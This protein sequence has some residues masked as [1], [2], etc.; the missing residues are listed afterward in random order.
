MT[1]REDVTILVVDD[2]ETVLQ[3]VRRTLRAAGFDNALMC[4]DPRDVELLLGADRVS[5]ILLDLIMPVRVTN[6]SVR[7]RAPIR[8]RTGN[9][10][11]PLVWSVC[12]LLCGAADPRQRPRHTFS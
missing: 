3:G 11:C 4:A 1:A 7:D 8:W 6:E 10:A 9:P 2:D 5:L 12:L